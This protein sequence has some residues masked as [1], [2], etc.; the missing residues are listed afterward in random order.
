MSMAMTALVA[1]PI[2]TPQQI[3]A[4]AGVLGFDLSIDE[5]QTPLDAFGGFRPTT[6]G[7]PR[8]M[9]AGVEIYAE[10]AQDFAQEN[11]LQVDPSYVHA[12]WFRFGSRFEE[13]YSAQVVCAA[14]ASL[15][16][17]VFSDEEGAYKTAQE[18]ATEALSTLSFAKPSRP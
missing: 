7:Q 2:P 13:L 15:G 14:L 18:L 11:G 5:A 6:F 1:S 17:I 16:G 9:Q 12:I 4:A 8:P 10:N 3:E